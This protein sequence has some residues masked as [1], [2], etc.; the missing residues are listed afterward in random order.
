MLKFGV[1]LKT[2][3]LIGLGFSEG[4]F[5]QLKLGRPIKFEYK[6]LDI[7]QAG[8]IIIAFPS[9]EVDGWAV[10]L[11]PVWSLV[12]LNNDAMIFLRSGKPWNI[13]IGPNKVVMFWGQNEAD[14]REML[15]TLIG[16][17]TEDL[18]PTVGDGQHRYRIKPS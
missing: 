16:P 15:G 7:D 3:Q 18:S 1:K 13:V 6:N 10:R 8:G 12:E 4:N 2:G 9:P 5:E 17:E 11:P 14:M